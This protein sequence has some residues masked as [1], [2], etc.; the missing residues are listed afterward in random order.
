M[1][2]ARFLAVWLTFALGVSHAQLV[3]SEVCASNHQTLVDFEGDSP[4]FI[5]LLNLG[6][7]PI[8][9]IEY[10]LQDDQL[11][12]LWQL[13]DHTLEPGEYLV[14]FASGKDRYEPEYHTNF[15][16]NSEG[17]HL[18]LIHETAPQFL[19]VPKLQT[20]HSYGLDLLTGE[21][22][23]YD[24]PTPGHANV[25]VSFEGYCSP[26]SVSHDSGFYPSGLTLEC[27]SA[28][29]ENILFAFAGH[30]ALSHGQWYEN[31]LAI[32]ETE[33]VQFICTR[34]GFLPSD[35]VWRTYFTNDLG[36]LP[37]LSLTVE[38]DLLFDPEIGLF[39]HGT[40]ADQEWPYFGANFWENRHIEVHVTY[41]V[42]GQIRVSQ[43]CD[44]RIHGNKGTRTQEQRPMRLVARNRHGHPYFLDRLISGKPHLKYKTVVLRNGGGDWNRVH[45]TDAFIQRTVTDSILK[46]DTRGSEHTAVYINGDFFGLYD[47]QEQVNADYTRRNLD[48]PDDTPVTI[49][50]QEQEAVTGDFTE[51]D[52]MVDWFQN[53]DLS[54]P[55]NYLMASEQ[56]DIDN[57]TDYLITAFFW[58]NTDWPGNN[59]KYH[60]AEGGKW[61]WITYDFDVSM[62]SVGWVTEHTNNLNR[63]LNDFQHIKTIQIFSALLEN[64]Q[65]QQYFINR[66][67]DLVNTVYRADRLTDSFNEM[68]DRVQPAMNLHF[69]RWGSNSDWW[70][71]YW[72]EPRA[73]VFLSDRQFIA[74]NQLE[75]QFNLNGQ[76]ELTIET[77]PPHAANFSLNSLVIDEGDWQGTYFT[78][79]PISLEAHARP[80]YEFV[81][82][83]HSLNDSIVSLSPSFQST[84]D[85]S[86]QLTAVYRPDAARLNMIVYPNPATSSFAI[87]FYAHSDAEATFRIYTSTGD[88]AKQSAVTIHL[89]V[90]RL[91]IEEHLAPGLYI[92]EMRSSGFSGMTKLLIVPH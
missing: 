17:E 21:Y 15:R 50:E 9:L 59:L 66:Y 84:F 91:T 85:E 37:V 4:D 78:D 58:N 14:I 77:W 36:D 88:L 38:P 71:F 69:E 12:R 44:M 92:I 47:F 57:L 67:A 43:P 5:E 20:D 48:L 31:P 27:Q 74:L 73:F 49:L 41:F 55:S 72:L 68:V 35:P 16:I 19:N 79:V 24:Q 22:R 18:F 82:W 46:T 28:A 80:G 26:P 54:I 76:Y 29:N 1:I 11:W 51:F 40:N 32:P 81:H 34:E 63:V 30:S 42:N 10:A 62:N 8:S 3:I 13:P 61:R 6:D 33:V 7:D 2:L 60:K 52:Q 56:V 70:H 87:E 53:T 65:Y 89:G 83:K 64:T 23:F 45:L 75:H 90:N 86:V 39:M 25:E